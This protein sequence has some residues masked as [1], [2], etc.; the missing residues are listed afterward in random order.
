M[1]IGWA[2]K[3]GFGGGAGGLVRRGFSEDGGLGG[4]DFDNLSHQKLWR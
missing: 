1:N 2:G 4:G 3:S